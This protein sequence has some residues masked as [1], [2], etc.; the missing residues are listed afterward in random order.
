MLLLLAIVLSVTTMALLAAAPNAG[1]VQVVCV[2]VV[3]P[4]T[5]QFVPPTVTVAVVSKYV[6]VIVMA[7]PASGRKM[8][9]TTDT[10]GASAT[11]NT[12]GPT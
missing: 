2:D 11:R 6:P 1:A 12:T 9:E 4:V 7:P 5:G 3:V 8:G 10:T